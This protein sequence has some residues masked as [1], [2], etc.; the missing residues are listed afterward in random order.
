MD[1]AVSSGPPIQVT[2]VSSSH[3][4]TCNTCQVAFRS[5]ELQRGHMRSEWHRYNLKRR[6]AS[7]P[8]LASEVFAEKVLTAQASSSAAAAKAS[9]ETVC[10]A[11]QKT[12][13][14]ENA[15][16][17]HI[18]SQ[19]HK[20][21]VLAMHNGTADGRTIVND[22][23]MSVMSSTF[24]LG[25][26]VGAGEQQDGEKEDELS[27]ELSGVAKGLGDTTVGE[28]GKEP[29][30]SAPAT[31][32]P[33]TTTEN[34][35][36]LSTLSCI[37]CNYVSPSINLNASHMGKIHGMFIPEQSYLI[38]L[39]GLIKF[40]A[41]KVLQSHE[42]LYCSKIKST[43]EGVR[44]HMR[45]KGHCIIAFD[46]EEQMID[47]GQFYDFR[48]TYSDSEE[49]SEGEDEGDRREAGMKGGAKLGAK[50]DIDV[51]TIV[52]GGSR[53]AENI[54]QGAADADGWE[55]DTSESSLDSEDL[56]AVPLDDHSHQYERLHKHPHH[57]HHD[58]RP[59][60]NADG[61]HSHAHHAHPHAVYRSEYE[62]YLPT[63]R[64][65]GH[66]SLARYYRQNLHRY[67]SPSSQQPET[68]AITGS[69]G[70]DINEQRGRQLAARASGGLGMVGV[71]GAKRREI[72]AVEKRER[73]RE[74]RERDRYQ[75]GVEKRGNM[76]KHFRVSNPPA[77]ATR[78]NVELILSACL[79]D[80]LL[81]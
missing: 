59:H 69:A 71:S 5:G 27:G 39:E 8:P 55:T 9:Y 2:P 15:Y 63:G 23:V 38:D 41:E 14:S 22:E 24:S 21:R 54:V 73:K 65:A 1:A 29:K 36:A 64:S 48:S 7:L 44:T 32:T 37:F 13:Y 60:R 78:G 40:L 28:N 3:P 20:A 43:P 75:W 18:A 81:Q 80:P 11:C 68:R 35:P 30:H 67:P 61:W 6:V 79:Q 47:V 51:T 34:S 19:K 49:D 33:S 76:Q 42:C 62:L 17:N 57:S 45:D 72:K 52:L 12:Y 4:F 74:G 70:G 56:C 25:E 66:R 53:G 31:A 50:R 58:P 10:Q 46:T 26:P 77:V 16:R